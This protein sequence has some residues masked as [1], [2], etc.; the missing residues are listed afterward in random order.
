M[1]I[2]NVYKINQIYVHILQFC[3]QHGMILLLFTNLVQLS[4]GE[5]IDDVKHWIYGKNLAM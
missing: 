5:Y 2:T 1:Y 4:K 3:I